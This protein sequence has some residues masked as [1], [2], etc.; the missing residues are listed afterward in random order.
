VGAAVSTVLYC[1]FRSVFESAPEFNIRASLGGRMYVF[2]WL[3]AGFAVV[4][5]AANVASC[6]GRVRRRW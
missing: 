3:A 6:W 1:V 2:V 5:F 4:G